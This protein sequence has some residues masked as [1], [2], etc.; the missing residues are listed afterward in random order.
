MGIKGFVSVN[1]IVAVIHIIEYTLPK[2][3][4]I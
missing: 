4:L 3:R 2:K 1:N